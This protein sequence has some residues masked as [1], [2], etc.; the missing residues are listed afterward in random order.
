VHD[1]TDNG[2]V[3]GVD[4]ITSATVAIHLEDESGGGSE[5]YT[6]VIGLSGQTFSSNNVPSGGGGETQTITFTV[7]SIADLEADGKI[8]IQVTS[9][10]G[11]FLFAD[12]LL[13]AQVTKGTP[14][15]Q[16]PEPSTLLLLGAAFAAFG[17]R[18]R[19]RS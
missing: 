5:D 1:I 4:D 14:P 18:V 10:S 13:T 6:F 19:R 12:S 8:T 7:P 2:F 15:G 17:W 16:V 3:V 11:S 9:T